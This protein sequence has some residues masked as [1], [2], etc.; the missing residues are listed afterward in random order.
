MAGSTRFTVIIPTRSRPST[1]RWAL[2]SCVEQN[3]D[4]LEIIVSD[5]FSQDETSEIVKSYQDSR[6]KYI[7]PG[8][9]LGMS[10][11]WEFAL[12]H[13]TGDYVNYIGDDDAMLPRAFSHLNQIVQELSCVALHWIR[14]DFVYF[15][16][17]TEHANLLSI[18]LWNRRGIEQVSS[19][20]LLKSI[21]AFQSP[22]SQSPMIYSG[23][24]RR[25]LVESI[26][27][28]SGRFFNTIIPDVYSGVAVACAVE[29]F[30]RSGT[31]Y[32]ISGCSPYSIGAS[33]LD[34]N[35]TNAQP[36]QQ[37]YQENTLRP[38]AQLNCKPINAQLCVADSILFA[39]D[40]FPEVQGLGIDFMTLMKQTAQEAQNLDADRYQQY[41]TA[42]RQIAQCNNLQSQSEQLV[43][44]FPRRTTIKK[45][46][47]LIDRA[48]AI[49]TVAYLNC[50][51][52]G[53]DN[54][55]DASVLVDHVLSMQKGGCFS[56]K[57]RINK[58]LSGLLPS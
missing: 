51:D 45:L 16:P 10:E 29:Q 14:D 40:I 53:I 49:G 30:H 48:N 44:K 54:V 3:Y 4:N 37:F 55:Y 36:S 6:I 32:S 52:F 57:Y 56:L 25:S 42:I 11:H 34:V 15:W 27:Q 22:Y 43:S 17:Q 24:V 58:F 8:K 26:A 38:H 13:A 23:I 19:R 12:Q 31:P 28:R 50:A 18:S 41:I 2:K 33:V 39:R 5:N 7:N 20:D 35:S 21:Q 1:L 47:K 9:R 46:P